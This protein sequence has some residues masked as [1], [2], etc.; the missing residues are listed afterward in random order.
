MKTTPIIDLPA[1]ERACKA[2][3][4]RP[5]LAH[6]RSECLQASTKIS[7]ALRQ[8]EDGNDPDLIAELDALWN[9]VQELITQIIGADDREA[10]LDNWARRSEGQPLGWDGD[11]QWH[12]QQCQFSI[13]RAICASYPEIF[14]VH[15]R[16]AGR[17]K[18]ISAELVRRSGRSFKGIAIP[19]AALSVKASDA[20][21][22]LLR[23]IM[24]KDVIST[25]TP[26]GGPGGALIPTLLQPDE[27]IDVLRPALAIRQLGARIIANLS[28]NIDLPRMTKPSDSG[29]FAENS[30]IMRS[31]EEF[32][33][34][35]LRPRHC[36]AILEASRNMIGAAAQS[37]PDLEAVMRNDL[38]QVLAQRLDLTAIQGAGTAIEPLGI[39][40]DPNVSFLPPQPV[41][42]DLLVD[43][44]T[45]LARKNALQGSLAWLAGSIVRGLLLKLKDDYARPLGLDLLFQ[46]YPF[47]FTNLA[48]G[49][50]TVVNPLIFF[51]AGS[52]YLGMWSEID[53]LLNPYAEDAFSKGNTLLR[54]AMTVDI[55]KRWVDAFAYCAITQTPPANGA[56]V[57][58]SGPAAPPRSPHPPARGRETV[59]A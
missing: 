44:T 6:A 16:D 55:Q 46:G 11:A 12:R 34:I 14:G 57:Q 1:L 20:P 42:Y 5:Q 59:S 50:A 18:E 13:S 32:D 9:R 43:L 38:A 29:W 40:T 33:V 15:G 39:V 35:P 24:H 22:Q 58:P 27:Y 36:G 28:A 10:S 23:Q 17:E 45:E 56:Q 3:K 30:A 4:A 8:A 51:D 54:A 49:P 2:A 37:S 19:I 26:P 48:V 41:S 25:T 52:L 21:P 53:L 47:A 31:D 7:A